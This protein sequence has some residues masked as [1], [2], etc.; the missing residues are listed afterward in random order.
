MDVYTVISVERL[1]L[2][3]WQINNFFKENI[4]L[5]LYHNI[6]ICYIIV[7]WHGNS[8]GKILLVPVVVPPRE[9]GREQIVGLSILL[10][11]VAP[12]RCHHVRRE[13][14]PGGVIVISTSDL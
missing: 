5:L 6:S 1:G 12:H 14:R 3:F 10:V 9:M 2:M 7:Y 8:D 13:R 11:V 4:L